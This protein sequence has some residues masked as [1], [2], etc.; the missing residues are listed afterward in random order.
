MLIDMGQKNICVTSETSN[1]R[2]EAAFSS[3]STDH[4]DIITFT[5]KKVRETL[6][7]YFLKNPI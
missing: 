7:E 4:N 3:L 1:D 5:G 2:V 6:K